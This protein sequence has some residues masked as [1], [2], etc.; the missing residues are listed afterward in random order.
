MCNQHHPQ[1]ATMCSIPQALEHLKGTLTDSVPA[2]L[3]EE[4]CQQ[5]GHRWRQRDLGPVVTTHLFLQQVLHGNLAIAHLRRLSG[6]A[7]TDSAYCQARVRLPLALLNRLQR[8]V[9]DGLRAN[10]DDRAETRWR[11]H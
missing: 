3:I 10:G 8:A 11:G 9:T 4:L 2:Q 6:R 1:E 7:F 5:L